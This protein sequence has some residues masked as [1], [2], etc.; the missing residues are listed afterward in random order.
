MRIPEAGPFGDTSRDAS[1]LAI[2]AASFVNRPGSGC[3]ESVVTDAT[4]RFFVLL[5]AS[6]LGPCWSAYDSRRSHRPGMG[7][8]RVHDGPQ[9]SGREIVDRIGYAA[10]VVRPEQDIRVVLLRFESDV[11]G[12]RDPQRP[13]RGHADATQDHRERTGAM[14]VR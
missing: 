1:L 8:D 6:S 14:E 11:D 2:V 4:H 12:V 10:Y 13:E 9:Q 3:V 5:G 7:G